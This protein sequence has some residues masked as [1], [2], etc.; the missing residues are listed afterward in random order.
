MSY[1]F[2]QITERDEA[3]LKYVKDIK[4]SNLEDNKGFK[5]DFYFEGNPYFKNTVV[6]HTIPLF[7]LSFILVGGNRASVWP[8]LSSGVNLAIKNCACHSRK[9]FDLQLSKTYHMIDDD[10][11]I[12]ER[13]VG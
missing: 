13:A 4:S 8:L 9:L 6:C 7:S 1:L 5:L 10:E 3:A 2:E 12:L 11:P